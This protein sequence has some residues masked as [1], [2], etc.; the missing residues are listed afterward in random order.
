MRRDVV[1]R[2]RPIFVFFVYFLYAFKDASRQLKP[3]EL[4]TSLA[5]AIV[6]YSFL[7]GEF[8]IKF[9]IALSTALTATQTLAASQKPTIT[10]VS[11]AA[12]KMA[13]VCGLKLGQAY[14]NAAL[15][16]IPLIG[17]PAAYLF[18]PLS[19]G[20]D[21]RGAGIK[22][23]KIYCGDEKWLPLSSMDD[24]NVVCPFLNPISPVYPVMQTGES[25]S[26]YREDLI[27]YN[28]ASEKYELDS[29]Q[30]MTRSLLGGSLQ[31]VVGAGIILESKAYL[32]LKGPSLSQKEKDA[33]QHR[34]NDTRGKIS[35]A[36]LVTSLLMQ[37]LT[38]NPDSPCGQAKAQLSNLMKKR[39]SAN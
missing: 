32:T 26:Q 10:E 38:G 16:S 25:D 11:E 8:M 14:V 6:S 29:S 21:E 22:N 3:L 31:A 2:N 19:V 5:S 1:N 36:Y 35:Y 18:M 9:I 28:K 20:I 7:P 27:R 23:I 12:G 4:G 30:T 34:I 13:Y 24:P 33:I 15:E 37:S 17:A 39:D